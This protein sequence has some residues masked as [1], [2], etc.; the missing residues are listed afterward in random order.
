MKKNILILLLV[1]I[2][3]F[4]SSFAQITIE[5]HQ[6]M[7]AQ[8]QRM[9]AKVNPTVPQNKRRTRG[10]DQRLI[11]RIRDRNGTTDSIK[12]AYA[13]SRGSY[14]GNMG[15]DIEGIE[16]EKIERY[17]PKLGPSQSR[18]AVRTY[19][20]NNLILTQTDSVALGTI[21]LA[22][23]R[24]SFKYNS[25]NQV[26]TVFYEKYLSNQWLKEGRRFYTYNAGLLKTEILQSW[27]GS[28]YENSDMNEYDY[29]GNNL[30]EN[31]SSYWDQ[32]GSTWILGARYLLTY[33]P[34]NYLQTFVTQYHPNTAWENDG[35][36][37][38][39]YNN[40]NQINDVVVD[41]WVAS[42]WSPVFNREYVWS[43]LRL[44]K[45]SI[46]N[47]SSNTQSF[48]F[49]YRTIYT[50][51]THDYPLTSILEQYSGGNWDYKPNSLGHK[52]FYFYEPY[53]SN[54]AV[55]DVP[56][57]WGG[58]K[59]YPNPAHNNIIIEIIE[60]TSDKQLVVLDILGT[61]V[62]SAI[63]NK[64]QNNAQIDVSQL[65]RGNYFL[66]IADETGAAYTHKLN[67]Q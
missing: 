10:Q 29:V 53:Q 25:S 40:A 9:L 54:V 60:N 43:G 32:F 52:W 67:K 27:N 39:T 19:D 26:D 11:L 4:E 21:W 58:V 66:R 64:F 47:W 48:D 5:Q 12:Y 6:F 35:R 28:V 20:P 44:A 55:N 37:T 50:F 49:N 22:D 34:N 17:F 1:C 63:M 31:V 14:L 42:A 2:G 41:D 46:N 18:K 24:Q 30:T 56:T 61:K 33:Y 7:Q 59:I 13:N 57:N 16:Y 62:A 38:Y 3:A 51:G 65:A 15:L 23:K 8:Q 36:S 45:E